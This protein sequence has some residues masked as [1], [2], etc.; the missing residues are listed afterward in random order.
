MRRPAR[1][2]APGPEGLRIAFYLGTTSLHAPAHI[3][4]KRRHNKS[5]MGLHLMLLWKL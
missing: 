2:D 3:L 4:T 1:L 5:Q